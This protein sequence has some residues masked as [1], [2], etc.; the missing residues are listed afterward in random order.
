MK[1]KTIITLKYLGSREMK[2]YGNLDHPQKIK[3]V[4]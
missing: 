3:Y 2:A 4:G 1:K